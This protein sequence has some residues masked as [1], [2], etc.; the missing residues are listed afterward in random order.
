MAVHKLNQSTLDTTQENLSLISS[1]DMPLIKK[2][3]EEGIIWK[4]GG[5][6]GKLGG[7]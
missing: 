5:G 6:G 1:P 7:Q 4:E 3:K 2:K